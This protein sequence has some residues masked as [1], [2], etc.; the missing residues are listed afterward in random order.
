MYYLKEFGL[1]VP[2]LLLPFKN[3]FDGYGVYNE[4]L[5]GHETLTFQWKPDKYEFPLHALYVMPSIPVPIVKL[6]DISDVAGAVS[7][8]FS[9]L[10][11][12]RFIVSTSPVVFCQFGDTSGNL[13]KVMI[14]EDILEIW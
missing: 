9:V 7:S 11:H 5:V 3:N 13:L 1:P 6:D 10:F 12:L 2:L 8:Q 4:S 14:N